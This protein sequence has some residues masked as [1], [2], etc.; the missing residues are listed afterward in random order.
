MLCEG[1]GLCGAVIDGDDG[2]FEVF[3]EVGFVD[4]PLSIG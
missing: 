2:D 1:D 4:E 3:V